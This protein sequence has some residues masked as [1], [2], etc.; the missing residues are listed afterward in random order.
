M[1]HRMHKRFDPREVRRASEWLRQHNIRRTG[2]L[3]L[4]GPGETMESAKTSL[5]FAETLDLDMLKISLGVRIYPHTD[6]ARIAREQGL[7][8]A[9]DDLLQPRFYMAKGLEDSLTAE[10]SRRMSL[11]RSWIL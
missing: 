11:Q 10:V 3:L 8:T 2:F 4:G 6:V 5:D 7:I 1:L 9:E